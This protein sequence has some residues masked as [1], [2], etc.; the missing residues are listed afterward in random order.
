MPKRKVSPIPIPKSEGVTAFIYQKVGSD[1]FHSKRKYS[2]F[3]YDNST[4][5]GVTS[6]GKHARLV[7][8]VKGKWYLY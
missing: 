8:K 1:L 7:K 6:D 4:T 5:K 3:F 2:I